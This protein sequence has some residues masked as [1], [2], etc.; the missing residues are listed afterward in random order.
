M[1]ALLEH[2]R[3]GGLHARGALG[4][5]VPA[6]QLARL[7]REGEFDLLVMGTHGHRFLADM[8]LGQTV[9]PLLHRLTIP[10]LVVPTREGAKRDKPTGIRPA[11]L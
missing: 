1:A 3:A 11:G 2:L 10:V 5:G 4:Y 7:A 8:A 9:A 6:E